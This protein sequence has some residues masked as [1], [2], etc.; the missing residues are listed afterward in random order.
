MADWLVSLKQILLMDY[1]TVYR[2]SLTDLDLAVPRDLLQP[3]DPK[4]RIY[5]Q[6][7]VFK[8]KLTNILLWLTFVVGRGETAW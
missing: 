6:L 4:L 1:A 8:A 7:I 2:I 5:R 3:A